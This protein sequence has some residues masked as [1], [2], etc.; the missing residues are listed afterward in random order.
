MT[1]QSGATGAVKPQNKALKSDLPTKR[2]WWIKAC[3]AVG[4]V[5]LSMCVFRFSAKSLTEMVGGACRH[6]STSD[7]A[8]N[9]TVYEP[10][11]QRS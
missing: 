4:V 11:A 7:K 10:Q 1:E 2:S 3:L 5:V 6:M 8:S 9:T